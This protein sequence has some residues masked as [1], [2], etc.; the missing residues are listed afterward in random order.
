MQSIFFEDLTSS[1][2]ERQYLWI[3]IVILSNIM[4]MRT[5]RG[6]LRVEKEEVSN[7]RKE[8][9]SSRGTKT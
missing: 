3:L 7:I 8:M 4:V 6:F 9:N 5:L 2:A 1:I